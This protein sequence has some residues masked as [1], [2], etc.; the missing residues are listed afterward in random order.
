MSALD[1]Q[2]WPQTISTERLTLRPMDAGDRDA[3]IDLVT[4]REAYRHLGG[5]STLEEAEKAVQPP[6]GDGP[7][8]FVV[9]ETVVGSVAGW[10]G[11]DRHPP[12]RPGHR[13][14]PERPGE[15]EVE[16]HYVLHP[17]YWGKGFGSEASR[18]VLEWVGSQVPDR[19][20]IAITQTAN[21]RSVAMLHRL[22]FVKRDSFMEFGDEQTLLTRALGQ[23]NRPDQG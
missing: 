17:R 12:E 15:G 3:I 23:R 1:I 6:Y 5:E 4:N 16:L 9:L 10:F 14:D 20:V 2:P 7:G 19:R 21:T 13:D 8:S 18:A 11:V 22:G